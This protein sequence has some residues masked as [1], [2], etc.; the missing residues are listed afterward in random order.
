MQGERRQYRHQAVDHYPGKHGESILLTSAVS[1][2]SSKFDFIL[3]EPGVQYPGR[4][5]L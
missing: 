1:V 2:A 5:M 4:E 3:R